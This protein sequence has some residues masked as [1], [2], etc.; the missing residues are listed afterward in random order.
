ME[1]TIIEIPS[2]YH[3]QR[4]KDVDLMVVHAMAEWVMDDKRVYHHCTDWLNVLKLSVHAFCL[5]DGRIVQS[6]DPQQVAYHAAEFNNTSVGMEFIVAGGHNYDSFLRRMADR[7]NS[8]YTQA[9]YDAG[10]WWF[11]Q[12]ARWFDLTFE[13]IKTHRDLAPDRKKDPGDAFDWDTFK[14]A[15]EA[16]G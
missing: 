9:Q 8:P 14:A 1:P 10:G 2:K 13:Q 15:F 16:A 3:R 7:E 4:T 5:P 12:Q 11:R 6:V